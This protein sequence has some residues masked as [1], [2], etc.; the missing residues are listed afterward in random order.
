MV[1]VRHEE[2]YAYSG[3]IEAANYS[4]TLGVMKAPTIELHFFFY[5][6]LQAF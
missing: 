5:S 2:P 6:L 3:P 4:V 1:P